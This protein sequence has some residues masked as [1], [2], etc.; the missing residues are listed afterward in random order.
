MKI[1]PHEIHF[2]Y[3]LTDQAGEG[4]ITR[5][6]GLI[7]P[8]EAARSRE[9]GLEKKRKE[10]ISTRAL[11]RFVLS[12][13][14]GIPARKLEFIKNRHGKPELKPGETGLKF[15]ISHSG[16]M[17]AFAVALEQNLGIDVEDLRRKVDLKIADRFFTKSEIRRIKT[18]PGEKRGAADRFLEIWTLKESYIKARGRGLSIP[19]DQL[20]F[21]LDPG[22]ASIRFSETMD[23]TPEDWI[24]FS[25]GL[26]F[27]HQ[28][29]AA[30]N[31]PAGTDS[32]L[33]I[34][35]CLPFESIEFE[36]SLFH[37]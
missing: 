21:H 23:D 1:R 8:D 36:R 14:S 29:A 37:P 6:T 13:F 32:Q 10:F 7:H 4:K 15:S 3:T 27:S 34:H 30:L 2:F 17:V 20:S 25:F 35:R 11:T 24:F 22:G 33:K 5:W 31:S 19:L 28:A 18:G 16:N 9:F 26:P 12:E